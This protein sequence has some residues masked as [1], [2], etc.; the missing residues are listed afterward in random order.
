MRKTRN[1][2]RCTV[3]DDAMDARRRTGKVAFQPILSSWLVSIGEAW[4]MLKS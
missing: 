3:A 4:I 1:P 2:T